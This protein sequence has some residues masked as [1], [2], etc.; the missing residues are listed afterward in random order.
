MLTSRTKEE[1]P[2]SNG[3]NNLAQPFL[4]LDERETARPAKFERRLVGELLDSKEADPVKPLY[5]LAVL[6]MNR[7]I[8]LI[9]G[10]DNQINGHALNMASPRGFEP[11][12]P[13]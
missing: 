2:S 9:S 4:E 5:D 3:I 1:H 8:Y 11:L 13:P 6:L 12:L 7:V 10:E